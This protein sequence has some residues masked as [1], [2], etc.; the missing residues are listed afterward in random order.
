MTHKWFFINTHHFNSFWHNSLFSL[1]ILFTIF[2]NF[3]FYNF[4]KFKFSTSS[5]IQ[6]F[7]LS[8]LHKCSLPINYLLCTNI[9]YHKIEIFIFSYFIYFFLKLKMDLC[10][11]DI[12]NLNFGIDECYKFEH[13]EDD[14]N[15]TPTNIP[16]SNL[17][18]LILQVKNLWLID[19]RL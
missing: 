11:L 5:S 1:F 9:H 14:E 12:K 4:F 10:Y 8:T 7:K 2:S 15:P 6:G 19:I 16:S 17:P 18:N 13:F 3:S